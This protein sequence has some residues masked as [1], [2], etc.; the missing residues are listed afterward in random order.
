MENASRAL[1]M[2]SEILIGI[3]VLTLIVVVNTLFGNFS[4]NMHSKMS[5]SEKA[6]FNNKFYIYSGRANITTTEIVTVINFAKQ[7]N[8]YY[9]L[10][11]NDTSSVY[12]I[13]VKID[14]ISFFDNIN[15]I[16]KDSDYEDNSKYIS[17]VNEFI[18][19]YNKKLY[20]CNCSNLK[21]WGTEI[22]YSISNDAI[23]INSTTGLVN[24]I[25]FNTVTDSAIENYDVTTKDDYNTVT[26]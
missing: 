13:D 3:L 18:A 12:Y 15:Y 25:N 14:G 20:S 6:E 1:I 22:T 5:E 21:V 10:K 16:K 17:K 23:G 11:R 8:D 9:E 4:A 2:A 19:K 26:N 7:Q 24:F